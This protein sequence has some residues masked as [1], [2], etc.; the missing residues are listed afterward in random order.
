MKFVSRAPCRIS[1]IGGG[2]DVDPFAKKFG[3]KLY[4]GTAIRN[5]IIY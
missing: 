5:I 2:T 1:L 3:G 4:V